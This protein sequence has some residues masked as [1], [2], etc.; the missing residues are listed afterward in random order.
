M[1]KKTINNWLAAIV[2][3]AVFVLCS[4]AMSKFL[5]DE[6]VPYPAD[7]RMWTHV[8]TGLIGPENPN[9]QTSGGYHH[10]YANT[11]AMQGYSSGTFPNGSMIVFDVLETKEQ[12]GNTLEGSRKHVDVMVK[13]SIRFKATG[14]WGYEEFDKDSQVRILTQPLKM[15]CFACHSKRKDKDFIFSAFRK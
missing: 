5:R 14:G 2:L 1:K 12:N 13:D 3:L 4:G 7:Y 8:K 11:K 9:F 15:Q 10:I 6:E